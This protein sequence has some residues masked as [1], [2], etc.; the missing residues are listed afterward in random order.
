MSI[1]PM[2]MHGIHKSYA[3]PDSSNVELALFGTTGF[4][5]DIEGISI[6]KTG[7]ETGYIIVSDQQANRFRFFPR[8]GVNGNHNHPELKFVN[9]ST[10]ESDGSDITSFAFAWI[11]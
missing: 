9:A 5:E 11:S 4:T 2:K 3:H 7:L 6:Y 10:V 8:E 1:I